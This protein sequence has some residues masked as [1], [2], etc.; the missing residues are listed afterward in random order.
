LHLLKKVFL[1]QIPLGAEVV[2]HRASQVGGPGFTPCTKS[3]P[4]SQA[5]SKQYSNTASYFSE[6]T[7]NT[8]K[9][10]FFGFHF[11]ETEEVPR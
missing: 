2:A 1:K 7:E 8:H 9:V 4:A 10:I 5:A 11:S 3:K 6:E